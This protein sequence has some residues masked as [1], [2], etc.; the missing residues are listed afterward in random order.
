[1]G[2]GTALLAVQESSDAELGALGAR[3]GIHAGVGTIVV[4]VALCLNI[5]L[6]GTLDL[7]VKV[8]T[9]EGLLVLP[10]VV[11]LDGEGEDAEAGVGGIGT[12]LAFHLPG[13][14]LDGLT[15]KVD[16][17]VVVAGFGGVEFYIV[18]TIVVVLDVRVDGS[19]GTVDG[20][21]KVIS[22]IGSG[23]AIGIDGMDGEFAWLVIDEA[24]E[25]G[26]LGPG[27]SSIGGRFDVHLLGGILDGLIV[28]GGVDMVVSGLGGVVLYGVGTVLVVGD[29]GGQF[30]GAS[31][32]DLERIA[33]IVSGFA[34]GID[35]M[36]GEHGRLEGLST[37][38]SRTLGPGVTSTS[39]FNEHLVR[40]SLDG[41]I[42]E[43]DVDKVV[44]GC[45]DL[46]GTIEGTVVVIVQ[47]GI[48]NF[49]GTLNLNHEGISSVFDGLAFSVHRVNPEG[50]IVTGSGTL[51]TRTGGIGVSGSGTFGLDGVRASLDVLS[52]Q[53]YTNGVLASLGNGVLNGVLA[54]A[55][56]ANFGVDVAI[57]A[58]YSD[59]KHVTAG[60]KLFVEAVLSNDLEVGRGEGLCL[61]QTRSVSVAER[62]ISGPLLSGKLFTLSASIL[63]S[64]VTES[65]DVGHARQF[66]RGID[67]ISGI[68]ENGDLILPQSGFTSLL[69]I[70]EGILAQSAHVMRSQYTRL[71]RVNQST[72]GLTILPIGSEVTK[73]LGDVVGFYLLPHPLQ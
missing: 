69:G 54:I 71:Q 9:T 27:V 60:G 55:R 31:N 58:M 2:E 35:G 28:E 25:G 34:I 59:I 52:P 12:F 8:I 11:G 15:L 14:V 62:G 45:V 51:N 3:E 22:T 44:A 53:L 70:S 57:R 46:V 5:G 36:D 42:I 47:L 73:G 68:H 40:G 50:G 7:D 66:V 13:G 24:V 43:S 65:G 26:T 6:G 23:V 10:L 56:V 67:H 64:I 1:L 32:L 63:A 20:N 30:L 61:L 18:G 29:L 72:D 39:G 17:E 16:S 33:T 37:L 41:F 49:L 4:V 21:I 48:G 38:E 19:L